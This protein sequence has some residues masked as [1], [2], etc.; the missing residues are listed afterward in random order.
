[1]ET[2]IAI[3]LFLIFLGGVMWLGD[4]MIAR[5]KL[6][7]ADRYAVWNYGCRYQPGGF[8]ADTIHQRFFDSSEYRRPTRVQTEKETFD[9]SLSAKGQV[10]LEMRMPEWTRNLFNAG[11]AIYKS[12]VPEESTEL[13]GRSLNGSHAV[14]MRTEE[15]SS[16]DYIR[17]KYGIPESGKVSTKWKEIYNEKWPYDG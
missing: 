7:I 15:K 5:Q 8:D 10:R 9:W 3:P 6:M 17:N 2:V 1:M 11:A 16:P 13:T 12:G 14:L 4:L